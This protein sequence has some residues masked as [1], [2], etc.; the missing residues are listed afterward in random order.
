MKKLALIALIAISTASLTGCYEVADGEKIGMI[1]RVSQQGVFCKT[2][3]AEIIRGGFSGGSGVNGQAFHFTIE[4]PELVKQVQSAMEKQV[5][6]K[7]HYK[8]EMNSFCR[9]SSGDS[10]VQSIETI[11][12]TPA[13]ASNSVTPAGTGYDKDKVI[14][15]L[16]V[17]AELINELAKK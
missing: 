1:T 12:N 11:N 17:Q 3:E 2:W 6:V 14:R 9:S 15:L 4:N 10:F 5:E 13:Q 7:I 16:Q 8:T